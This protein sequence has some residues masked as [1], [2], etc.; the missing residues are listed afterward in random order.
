MAL[1]SHPLLSALRRNPT[2]AV[3]IALQIG[4]TLAILVNAAAIVTHALQKMDR[5][6]GLDTRDTFAIASGG[7]SK[8]FNVYSA[9]SE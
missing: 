9:S 8:H 3:L 2:G 5:P 6:T 7:L 1:T 4:I